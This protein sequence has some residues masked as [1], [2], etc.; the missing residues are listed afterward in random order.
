MNFGDYLKAFET[1]KLLN[2]YLILLKARGHIKFHYKNPLY[3]Q[4]LNIEI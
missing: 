4:Y 3:L 2:N 1:L